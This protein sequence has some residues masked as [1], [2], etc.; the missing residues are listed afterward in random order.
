MRKKSTTKYATE[1]TGTRP[2]NRVY[3]AHFELW[4]LLGGADAKYKPEAATLDII[5]KQIS[6]LARLTGTPEKEGDE[7]ETFITAAKAA[8]AS[9]DPGA[10]LLTLTLAE[11]I[12]NTYDGVMFE[13]L[14]REEQQRARV[15]ADVPRR[16]SAEPQTSVSHV[17]ANG[18]LAVFGILAG[19]T[20]L[21]EE[22][23]D[24]NPGE[25]VR[26]READGDSKSYIAR[27]VTFTDDGASLSN[28]EE[29][30]SYN[31]GEVCE[32]ARLTGI[33]RTTLINRADP[34]TDAAPA[35][36]PAQVIDLLCYRQAHPQR[37]RRPI[38]AEKA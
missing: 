11:L 29:E 33:T 19:D 37:I 27:V 4:G 6:H 16:P 17:G 36:S 12:K 34:A 38:F 30:F 28:G 5:L 15:G 3:K 13:K 24:A 26:Y 21:W 35:D 25:I 10:W 14:L 32:L 31:P 22:T 23:R 1:P 20:L 18:T 9:K 8:H 7:R 2:P